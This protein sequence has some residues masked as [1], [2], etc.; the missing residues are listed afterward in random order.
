MKNYQDGELHVERDGMI[1]VVST[2]G[3]NDDQAWKERSRWGAGFKAQAEM[4][5]EGDELRPG[6]VIVWSIRVVGEQEPRRG[7]LE[8]EGGDDF[9]P[10]QEF[11]E[12][13]VGEAI[14]RS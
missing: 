9:I 8:Y 1:M 5:E 3:Y 6:D 2:F 4:L 10:I 14:F 13:R 12:V 7:A 11:E